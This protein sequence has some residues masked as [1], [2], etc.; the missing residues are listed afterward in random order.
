MGDVDAAETHLAVAMQ[1]VEQLGRDDR[2]GRLET[3]TRAGNDR[4]ASGLDPCTSGS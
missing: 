2:L 1:L 3:T 4:D